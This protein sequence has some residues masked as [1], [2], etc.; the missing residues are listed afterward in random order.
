L[1]AIQKLNGNVSGLVTGVSSVFG[2]TGAVSAT[3][4]DYNTSQVTENTN[5][6]YTEGRVSANTDVAANTA[7]RHAAVTIGTANGLSLST[8]ALSLAAANTTTT[9]A[10]TSTDWNT[11]NGKQAALNGTGFVKISG[12]TIS[13]DNT[14]YLPLGG[15]TLTGGLSGTTA[16]FSGILTTPQVKAATSAGLSIN[17]NSG[18]QVADFGAGGSANITFFGGLSGT[19]ASFS[20][21][22]TAVGTFKTTGGVFQLFNSTTFL[23]G[24]YPYATWLGSGSDYTPT[25]ASATGLYFATGDSSTIR[26]SITSSGNQFVFANIS[27][28]WVTEM[29]NDASSIP[30]GIY[31]KYR[32][33]TPNSTSSSFLRFDDSS[34]NRFQVYSNGGIA[35]YTANNNPLSDE[36]LKKE[37]TPLESVWNK[38]KAIEVVKYKFNDQTHDDFNMGVIAQ[39]LE[40]VAPEL[41]NPEGWGT[42]AEDGTPY[43]S[44]WENDMHYYTMKALQE[45]MSKIE[46][47]QATITSLQ[48]RLDKAGL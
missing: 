41:V 10:L 4:G 24:L 14:S 16:T 2:R 36:R 35:N 26:M 45:S 8:Q 29:Y 1:Q 11:F 3:S 6:Y 39:Q 15:G 20:S 5:L 31:L 38:F 23:G 43:K 18:T 27:N 7:A 12:T 46:T 37:I 33:V 25:L 40:S 28:S 42:L 44:I 9:G 34:A 48:D 19:S 22:V 30:Y 21:S 47:L 13:Y 32:N 17:A